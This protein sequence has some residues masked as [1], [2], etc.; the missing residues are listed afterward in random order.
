MYEVNETQRK[1]ISE[2][3]LHFFCFFAHLMDSCLFRSLV[4]ISSNLNHHM[5][6]LHKIEAIRT[7]N[8]CDFTFSLQKRS[9]VTHESVKDLNGET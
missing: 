8:Q 3:L 2:F 1:L 5:E 9:S 4:S 6:M 7:L